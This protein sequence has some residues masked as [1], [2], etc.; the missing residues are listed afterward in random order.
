[1]SAEVDQ[2]LMRGIIACRALAENIH[3]RDFHAGDEQPQ[4]TLTVLRDIVTRAGAEY[5]SL[6]DGNGVVVAS[7]DP[8]AVGY[9]FSDWPFLR[10]AAS[11]EVLVFPSV[12]MGWERRRVLYVV[13][14][15]ED[16]G[17]AV[18][19]QDVAALDR[20]LGSVGAPAALVYRDRYEV[21]TN[22][23]GFRF[24][25]LRGRTEVAPVDPGEESVLAMMDHV[26]PPIGDTLEREGTSFDVRHVPT[27][28]A[29]WQILVATPHG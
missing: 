16:G 8:Q 3:V 4:R 6:I 17:A 9:D 2:A 21:A 26:F 1:V 5:A 18:L 20:L 12:G 7:T 28:V 13:P 23:P 15:G 27:V 14:R 25:R 19:R 22:R 24:D 29:D 11:G 10:R